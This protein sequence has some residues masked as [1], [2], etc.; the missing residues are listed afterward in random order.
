MEASILL[1]IQNHM[2]NDTLTA[3]FSRITVLG[4]KGIFWIVIGLILLAAAGITWQRNKTSGNT[5]NPYLIPALTCVLSMVLSFIIGNLILKNVFARVRPYDTISDLILLAEKPDDFSFPSGH[6]TFSFACAAALWLT[7]PKK[8]R[9][10]AGLLLILAALIGFSRLYLGVHY[11]T[12]V[13]AGAVLGCIC[14][15]IAQVVVARKYR[16]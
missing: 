1:W 10:I 12:D 9:W 7:I 6:T 4:D 3:N 2:R 14:A 16:Q 5:E 13:L 8:K 11:P 15:K